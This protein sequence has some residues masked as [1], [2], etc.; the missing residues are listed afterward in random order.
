MRVHILTQHST[1][2]ER[3]KQF[4]YYCECCDFGTLGEVLY[5]R[6]LETKKHNEKSAF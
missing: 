5:N 3:K 6:H 2:E 4:K 1:P